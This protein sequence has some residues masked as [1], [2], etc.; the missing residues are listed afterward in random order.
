MSEK[1]NDI[2][3]TLTSTGLP[4]V[5]SHFRNTDGV[6]IQPPYVTYFGN[7]QNRMLA[8]STLYWR[9]NTY[10]VQYY[11]TKKDEELEK[12]FEDALLADGW[13]FEKSEDV[14]IEDMD[15]FYIYY[16]VTMGV[17]QNG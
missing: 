11:F 3:T 1:K 13:I 8:D 2:Y 12:T 10:E 9:E 16:N 7:G 5:Y 17:K 15:I 6:E 4:C 14:Y